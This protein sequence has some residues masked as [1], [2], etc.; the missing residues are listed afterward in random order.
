VV[1]HQ[2]LTRTSGAAEKSSLVRGHG[3]WLHRLGVPA[4]SWRF[5]VPPHTPDPWA[6]S[7][8]ALSSSVASSNVEGPS[9]LV[10]FLREPHISKRKYKTQTQIRSGAVLSGSTRGASRR[11]SV[12]DIE[13][14]HLLGS[15]RRR[16]WRTACDCTRPVTSV[17]VGLEAWSSTHGR[18]YH[19]C[20]WFG[21]YS[22]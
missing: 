3:C 10:T 19:C 20:G 1:P 15:R 16:Q 11:G 9:V 8:L 4:K 21:V 5:R 14:I 6:L 13:A 22:H 2:L 17:T 12:Q 7:S 18:L